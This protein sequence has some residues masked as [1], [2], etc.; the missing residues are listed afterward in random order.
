MTSAKSRE[1]EARLRVGLEIALKAGEGTLKA[2]YRGNPKTITKGD[3]TPVT[4]ADRHAE[5]FLRDSIA[6]AF[7][8]DGALGEEYGESSGTSGFRWII[9]PID[10]TQSFIRGVPLYGTLVGVEFE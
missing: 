8:R 5:R 10:G 3:G 9:D 4:L 7:P 1:V 6:K 2:F